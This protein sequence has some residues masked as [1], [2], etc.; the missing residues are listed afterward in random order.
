MRRI[1]TYD[2]SVF[3][4]ENHIKITKGLQEDYIDDE[5]R[6]IVIELDKYYLIN[7][8]VPNSSRGLVKY[9]KV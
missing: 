3:V 1:E 2:T 7:T 5:G 6:A 9:V 8:Y 4:R